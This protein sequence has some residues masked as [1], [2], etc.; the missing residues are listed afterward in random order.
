LEW[1]GAVVLKTR[2]T[3]T[4]NGG[5]AQFRLGNMSAKQHDPSFITII[6]F[7]TIIT[8]TWATRLRRMGVP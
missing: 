8:E 6:S 7:T 2:E 4:K 5:Q 1:L 3:G